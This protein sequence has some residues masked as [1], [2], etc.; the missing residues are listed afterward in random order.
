MNL[1]SLPQPRATAPANHARTATR[2]TLLDA[3][4]QLFAAN[5]IEGTSVRDITTAAGTS[6]GA[7]TY[8]F[9]SKDRLVL[10]V[11]ARR[12]EP[13]NRARIARLDALEKAAGKRS[14]ELSQ[15]VKAL[16]RPSLESEIPGEPR[17]EAFVRLIGRCFL[18]PHPLL[19]KFVEEQFGEV[20]KRFDAAILRAVPEL[21]QAAL[22]WRM[23]F[24]IGALH[25]A[26]TV[27]LQFGQFPRPETMTT[28]PDLEEFIEALT[29]FV[30]AGLRAPLPRKASIGKHRV[31]AKSKQ[32]KS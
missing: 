7:V 26:Q 4:E 19:K 13:V 17:A 1:T 12:L 27:W 5:G 9:G 16:V 25:H 8:H 21:S 29:T 31:A 24:L 11:F 3:A 20:V 22:S 14:V 30:T 15:I 2:T 6:L 28:R 10:E 23:T 18:E 32:P